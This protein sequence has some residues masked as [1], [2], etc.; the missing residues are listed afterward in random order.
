MFSRGQTFEFN[1]NPSAK[2]IKSFINK[3]L[4]PPSSLIDSQELWEKLQ[5]RKI[6]FGYFGEEDTKF[7]TYVGLKQRL[8][9]VRLFH[10]FDQKF[11][12]LNGGNT[13]TLFRKDKEP[14]H[15]TGEFNEENIL[16]WFK[17]NL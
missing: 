6:G 3:A 15:F 2:S 4:K 1:R 14:L 12:E 16:T 17:T 8:S 7:N 13:L 9:G 10:S 11:K 5:N